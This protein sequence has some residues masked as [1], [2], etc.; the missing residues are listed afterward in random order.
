VNALQAGLSIKGGNKTNKAAYC[1]QLYVQVDYEYTGTT[2]GEVPQGSLY[3]I[4]P[5]AEYTGDMLVKIYLTNTANLLKAYQYLNMKVY[6]SNSVEAGGIPNYKVLSIENGVIEFTIIGGSANTYTVSVT[7]G[8]YCLISDNP[9]SW[10]TG[11]SI[12]P[13]F[14]C[15]VTQR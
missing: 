15:E 1:T 7:G 11:W 14:Y 8:S 10:G 12:T 4:T 5:H 6:V 13:E 9:D 3:N 2:E